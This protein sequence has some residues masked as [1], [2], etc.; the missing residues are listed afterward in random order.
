MPLKQRASTALVVRRR[1]ALSVVPAEH[2]DR[3]AWRESPPSPAEAT[4]QRSLELPDAR[5]RRAPNLGRVAPGFLPARAAFAPQKRITAV[6][7]GTH[8]G[9]WPHRAAELRQA[10]VPGLARQPVGSLLGLA[11]IIILH[12]DLDVATVP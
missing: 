5:L 8:R 12:P 2:F 4:G 7:R 3:G 1:T 6:H 9:R 11:R 10:L